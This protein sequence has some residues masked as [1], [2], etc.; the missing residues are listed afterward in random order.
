MNGADSRSLQTRLGRLFLKDSALVPAVSVVL[1]LAAGAL[2]MLAGGYDP[3]AAYSALYEGVFGNLYNMGET[4]RQITP[5]IFTGLSVAFAF[6]T[7]L[8]NI[9]AEGQFLVGSLAAVW[10]GAA[11]DA[12]AGV[13]VL[14]ALLAGGL[15]GALWGAVPGYLKA[16]RGVHEV[17][18]TIMMNWIALYLTNYLIRAYLKADAERSVE[19]RPT[20]SL[21]A[22]WLSAWFDDA[23]IHLGIVLA[24]LALAAYYVV[25]WKTRWGFELRAVGLNPSAAEYAGMDVSRSIVSAMMASGLLAGLGGAAEAL[26]VYGYM[27]IS[28]IFPG[29]GYDGIAVALLGANTPLGILL[30]A[31]LFGALNYGANT[32]QRLADVPIELIRVVIALVIFFVAASGIV[33]SLIGLFRRTKGKGGATDGMAS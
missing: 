27:A 2:L 16:K 33:R 24:L 21:Q 22:D 25:L 23:R 3:V 9:G 28:A 26:G 14:L 1:G 18:T 12:P 13:H 20:A 6:R 5:L 29:Y 19:I 17:I 10:V 31:M 8:F 15:A 30:G 7:G 11:I 32:M 4:I